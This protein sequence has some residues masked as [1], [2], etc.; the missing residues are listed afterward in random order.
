[1]RRGRRRRVCVDEYEPQRV[2][3]RGYECHA[4]HE[5]V[6]SVLDL[7]TGAAAAK[8]SSLKTGQISGV[9]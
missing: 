7:V 5:R 9:L 4:E 1:M 2:L 3:E 6:R 8:R